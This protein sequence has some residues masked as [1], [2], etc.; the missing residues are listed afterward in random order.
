[1]VIPMVPLPRM[2]RPQQLQPRTLRIGQVMPLQ[3]ILIHGVIQAETPTKIYGT[4]PSGAP[5]H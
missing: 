2:S 1:M 3:P 4:R 5:P